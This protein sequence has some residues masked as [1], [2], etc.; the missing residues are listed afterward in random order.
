MTTA[1]W[2]Q[3]IGTIVVVAVGYGALSQRVSQLREDIRELKGSQRD[4]G[5]RIGRLETEVRILQALRDRRPTRAL[6]EVMAP[7]DDGEQ[8]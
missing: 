8:T 5:Q 6:G 4:Q 7:A 3:L 2:L 1:Q